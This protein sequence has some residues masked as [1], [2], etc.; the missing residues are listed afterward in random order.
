MRAS[1]LLLHER[2]TRSLARCK[3]SCIAVSKGA[4][5]RITKCLQG[6]ISRLNKR[7]SIAAAPTPPPPSAA[8]PPPASAQAPAA[9]QR[10][11][12]TLKTAPPA[13]PPAPQRCSA[14]ARPG[15]VAVEDDGRVQGVVGTATAGSPNHTPGHPITSRCTTLRFKPH[16]HAVCATVTHQNNTLRHPPTHPPTHPPCAAPR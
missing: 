2:P 6:C 16:A 15:A 1:R 9:L 11:W 14:A 5:C 7:G 4:S 12:L 3:S 10:R 8:P 13:P